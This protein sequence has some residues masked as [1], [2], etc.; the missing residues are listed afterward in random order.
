[1]SNPHKDEL[2]EVCARALRVHLASTRGAYMFG[3]SAE[4]YVAGRNANTLVLRSG[5]GQRFLI[6]IQLS[7]YVEKKEGE[8]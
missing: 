6:K 2:T 5:G 1:M 3:A 4:V 7:G 8:Q